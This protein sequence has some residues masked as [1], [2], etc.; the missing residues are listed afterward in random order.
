MFWSYKIN[1]KVNRMKMRHLEIKKCFVLM[2]YHNS[3]W[4]SRKLSLL[5]PFFSPQI[6]LKEPPT[7]LWFHFPTGPGKP[8]LAQNVSTPAAFE[9]HVMPLQKEG[10]MLCISLA[11]STLIS[12]CGGSLQRCNFH[13]A[14][15]QAQLLHVWELPGSRWERGVRD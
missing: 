15:G 8:R 6:I 9:G 7:S 5:P 2:Y 14:S 4:Q 10:Q 1:I 12:G 13:F 3:C 11:P